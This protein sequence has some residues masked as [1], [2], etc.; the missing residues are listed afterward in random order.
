MPQVGLV[1]IWAG[2]AACYRVLEEADAGVFAG[3]EGLV[4]PDA[5]LDFANVGTA[6]HQQTQTGLT[7]TTADGQRQFAVQKHLMEGQLPAVIAAGFPKL[8]VQ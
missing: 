6:H 8:A 7:D 3:G 1:D 4:V 2:D 5:G